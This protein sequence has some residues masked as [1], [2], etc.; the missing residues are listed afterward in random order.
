[1][2]VLLLVAAAL[3]LILPSTGCRDPEPALPVALCGMESY[4]LL[5]A[6]EVGGVVASEEVTLLD[7][8]AAGIDGLLAAGGLADVLGPSPYGARVFRLRYRTQDRGVVREATTVAAFPANADLP[9]EL[10][11]LIYTHGTTGFSDPCAPSADLGG[12][13]LA[14]AIAARGYIVAAPD[15]LGLTGLGETVDLRHPYLI[16]EPTAIASWDAL[17]ATIALGAAEGVEAVPSHQTAIMGASQGGHAAFFTARYGPHYAPEFD[18]DAVLPSIPPID[19]REL[20]AFGVDDRGGIHGLLA[21]MLNAYRNWY[22]A[23]ASMEGVL[24]NDAP[25]NLADNIDTLMYP[26]DACD[27]GDEL[28]AILQASGSLYEADFTEGMRGGSVGEPWDCY[29]EVN[30]IN[31]APIPRGDDPPFFVAAGELDELVPL[32]TVT[33]GVSELCAS[34]YGIEL[35]VCQ[36][37]NHV[38][39]GTWSLREQLD[40]LNA[41]MA[42][43]PMDPARSCEIPAPSCCSGSDPAVCTS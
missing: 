11:L 4:E 42:G 7:L 37:A 27:A 36:D 9:A 43:E 28:G 14:A 34:G 10:P 5:P 26:T 25:H 38:Q 23:P 32:V 30:S 12:Q 1:M 21:A 3:L 15:Y 20:M 40:W 8:D 31:A 24:V 22:G 18:I 13:L 19:M 35:L 16:G 17:R 6:E 29:L 33:D 41:R 2:R 39:G